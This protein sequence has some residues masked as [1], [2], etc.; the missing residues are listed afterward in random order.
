MRNGTQ[1][2]FR[3]FALITILLLSF[4]SGARA[5]TYN[6]WFNITVMLQQTDSSEAS[7]QPSL[8][9]DS[10]G[11]VHLVWSQEDPDSASTYNIFYTKLDNSGRT[12]IAPVQLTDTDDY[13]TEPTCAA[14]PDGSLHLVWVRHTGGDDDLYYAKVS[15]DGGIVVGP[16]RITAGSAVAYTPEMKIDDLGNLHVA[17]RDG[18][19]G[20]WQVWYM[21]LD[22]SGSVTV[23]DKQV[24]IA[25]G[26]HLNPDVGPDGLGGAY[27]VYEYYGFGNPEIYCSRIAADG[28]FGFYDTRISNTAASSETPVVATAPDGS[29][30]VVFVDSAPGN[31]ELYY[32][33]VDISGPLLQVPARATYEND[34]TVQPSIA[35]RPNGELIIIFTDG[36]HSSTG[37]LY[38]LVIDVVGNILLP[39]TR[40]TAYAGTSDSSRVAVDDYG[41]AH[42]AWM[43]TGAGHYDIYYKKGA[44]GNTGNSGMLLVRTVP[45]DGRVFVDG[46]QRAV[47]G[48]S[49]VISEGDHEV[50]YG[51]VAG[52]AAPPDETAHVEAWEGTEITG[53]YAEFRE[54][55]ALI[56]IAFL[57]PAGFDAAG[58]AAAVNA[59]GHVVVAAEDTSYGNPEIAAYK[60]TNIGGSTGTDRLTDDPADSTHPDVILAGDDS[61]YSVWRDTRAS[62]MIYLEKRTSEGASVIGPLAVSADATVSSP[63][64]ATDEDGRIHVAWLQ[65]G[66]NLYYARRDADGAELLA[67]RTV[68]DGEAVVHAFDMHVS[69]TGEA[70]F[71]WEDLRGGNFNLYY[72]SLTDAG[73]P[74]VAPKAI[75]A[76]AKAKLPQIAPRTDGKLHLAWVDDR[77]EGFKMYGAA[78]A[79]DGTITNPVDLG[80][81]DWPVTARNT[82][83]VADA[84][85]NGYVVW[86]ARNGADNKLMFAMLSPLSQCIVE[87]TEVTSTTAE[88]TA[89]SIAVDATGG[90]HMAWL[91]GR[92]G[93]NTR[94]AFLKGA[95]ARKD[96]AYGFLEITTEN[97]EGMILVDG[98]EKLPG[99]WSGAAA[100]GSHTVSFEELLGYDTPEDQEVLLGLLAKEVLVGTYVRQ[101]GTL[102][103]TTVPVAG[104][105][106]VD[107][108]YKGDGNY[109]EVLGVDVFTV[110]FGDLLGYVTPADEEVTLVKDETTAVTGTYV[111]ETVPPELTVTA[112]VEGQAFTQRIIDVNGTASDDSGIDRVMV[113]GFIA[114][115][116]ENWQRDL[117]LLPGDN[118]ITVVAW[119]LSAEPNSTTVVRNVFFDADQDT[120][121][122]GMPDWWETEHGLNINNPG[123]ALDDP[124]GDGKN[125]LQEYQEDTDPHNADVTAPEVVSPAAVPN[126]VRRG[127][128]DTV[129]VTA[130][131]TDTGAGTPGV[132]RAELYVGA[133]PGV[134]RGVPLNP[135]DGAFDSAAEDA[136]AVLDVTAWHEAS[137]PYTVYVRGRDLAGNW[138][139]PSAILVDVVDGVP[140]AEPGDFVA[141]ARDPS[142]F[143]ELPITDATASSQLDVDHGADKLRDNDDETWWTSARFPAPEVA[144]E[145]DLD[146]G[147]LYKVSAFSITAGPKGSEK[148]PEAFMVKMAADP[149]GPWTTMVAEGYFKGKTGKKYSWW[150][151]RKGETFRYVRII[152]TQYAKDKSK[153]YSASIGEVRIE[154]AASSFDSIMLSWIAP[155]DDGNDGTAAGYDVRLR[156]D[157]PVTADNWDTS[158][159]LPDEPAPLPAGNEQVMGIDELDPQAHYYFGILT[160]DENDNASGVASTDADTS[161][162]FIRGINILEP[163]D[164][165]TIPVSA[166]PTYRWENTTY[167][168]YYTVQF[169]DNPRFKGTKKAKVKGAKEYTP[170]A[171]TWKKI[172]TIANKGGGTLYWRI[173]GKGKGIKGYSET[174]HQFAVDGGAINI[175]SPIDNI[176]VPF[177]DPGSVAFAW[178]NT[179]PGIVK[180]HVEINTTE[181]FGRKSLLSPK[182][183]EEGLAA[184]AI[185]PAG[186]DWKKIRKLA[187]GTGGTL[188]WRVRGWDADGVFQVVSEARRFFVDVGVLEA[189]APVGGVLSIYTV[190]NFAW[191]YAGADLTAFKVEI[192]T[193]EDFAIKKERKILTPRYTDASPLVP[194]KSDIKNLRKIMNRAWEARGQG[195]TQATIWWRVWG[196]TADKS[197]SAASE[198]VSYAFEQDAAVGTLPADGANVPAG[199]IPPRFEWTIDD[200]DEVRHVVECSTTPTFEKRTCKN[201]KYT[202]ELF[203][204]P[205]ASE[206]KK[207]KSMAEKAGVTTLY[208]RVRTYDSK[209]YFVN[210]SPVYSFELTPP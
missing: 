144:E 8:A 180:F 22:R 101:F 91:D 201:L 128:D 193:Q 62:E 157:E 23:A 7:I 178:T 41:S 145:I 174:Y 55:A 56:S 158:T 173:Q 102:E 127:Q 156:G 43:D 110:S 187:S 155:G 95:T 83:M 189:T 96:S 166:I 84:A 207:M 76:T 49:G 90:I 203:R 79:A 167:T 38:S 176:G 93:A 15:A 44:P 179:E 66:L 139:A 69:E 138:S 86:A 165:E 98:E 106:Y 87:G 58:V 78:L 10:N 73:D 51:E 199:E 184:W 16:T 81:Y 115:G 210:Y 27:I 175:T 124:D 63:R 54:W 133:D 134:G 18:R 163:A 195:E 161:E 57:S 147:D 107:G 46:V 4:A 82:A 143:E 85:G 122:D 209:K 35:F 59:G 9:V 141:A 152:M 177:A 169:S 146:M 108:E 17:W 148:P 168:S 202:V 47:G 50:S 123:D 70:Q 24:T 171:K 137:S 39:V 77:G 28:A 125:N 32:A 131:I 149:G 14:D 67:P 88:V 6:A 21:R 75:T 130:T 100:T 65:D 64:V 29:A 112:P 136:T 45:V 97:A 154:R 94:V 181:Q 11:Y 164:G 140:P 121:E 42:I 197:F 162:V 114:A 25:V 3:V 151:D 208:W 113:N 71:V 68:N 206:W 99:A 48:W 129:T 200:A 172:K 119:D 132:S 150:I 159:P 52:Y 74:D 33:R 12:S 26:G 183:P 104:A 13:N 170:D 80:D 5:Q 204:D 186:K 182:K 19:T 1:S 198:P 116:T 40:L 126:T 111:P 109:S 37:E 120:D 142:V 34:P 135:D 196:R 92:D 191:N 89:A 31:Y 194:M 188:W 2:S 36:R 20:D 60:L 205:S 185:D 192:S 105:I 103:V 118:T 72:A 30:S 117:E 53:T 160:R 61:L 153:L 190:P